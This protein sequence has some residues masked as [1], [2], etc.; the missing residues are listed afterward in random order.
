MASVQLRKVYKNYGKTE[1][2]KGVD[3]D[4]EA[5]QLTVFVGPS[6][7]GKSTILR[8]I[9]G[10]EEISGGDIFIDGEQANDIPPFKRGVGMVFQSYALYPHMT[11]YGNLSF[12]LSSLKLPKAEITLRIERATKM[13]GLEPYLKRKPKQLSGGQRQR[14]AMGR[15]IVRQPKVFLFDEPLSNLDASLRVRMRMEIA[16]LR[17]KLNATMI[18]VTHDQV[19]A[20]TLAHKIVVLRA[21]KVEQAGTPLEVYHQP[22]NKFV[23]SFLGSPSMNFIP[24]QDISAETPHP[25]IRLPNGTIIEIPQGVATLKGNIEFGIRPEHLSP[26]E[27]APYIIK[28]NVDA[29]EQ[30][31]DHLLAYVALDGDTKDTSVVA[32]L[33]GDFS[34]SIGQTINL[35]FDTKRCHLFD[36]QERALPL[37]SK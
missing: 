21:G 4:I 22:K 28:G 19:E 10:L 9:A 16:K 18:Y 12:G 34:V 11:V 33:P 17:S 15:A 6:G 32:K 2:I 13:L 37:Q 20:M 24:V 14:V 7:C 25:A 1:I 3:L 29:I 30:L 26:T 8:M 31:G 35:G 36:G 27:D 5:G 23:A